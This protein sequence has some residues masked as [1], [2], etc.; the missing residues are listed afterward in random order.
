MTDNSGLEQRLRRSCPGPVASPRHREELQDRLT[1]NLYTKSSS[2]PWTLSAYLAAAAGSAAL[3]GLLML[4]GGFQAA[5]NGGQTLLSTLR[6][7]AG[8]RPPI[9][10]TISLPRRQVIDPD[11]LRQY[12]TSRPN[13]M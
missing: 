8:E 6:Q 7:G 1:E 4:G 10:W 3:L 5:S 9:T 2:E 11:L 13:W 12:A